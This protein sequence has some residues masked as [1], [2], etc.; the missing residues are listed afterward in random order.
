MILITK[1]GFSIRFPAEDVRV[2]HRQARGVRGI[3]L[4]S[5]DCVVGMVVLA[6]DIINKDFYLL[7]ATE[8]GFAKRTHIKEYRRQAR[9]GKGIINVK[10]TERIGEVIGVVLVA[11]DDEVMCITEKGILIRLRVKEVRGTKRGT[12]GVKI[13][14]LK[15]KDNLA[16][17]T[18]IVS[19]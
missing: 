6:E 7:T 11:E 15:E 14:N 19:Q 17:L 5:D 1:E 3:K 8:K 4:S 10:I 18:R 9:G 16:S 12:Q 2:M 13:I